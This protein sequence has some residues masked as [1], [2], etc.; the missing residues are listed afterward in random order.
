LLEYPK[1][2]LTTTYF[3]RKNV[4][5]ENKEDKKLILETIYS[6]SGFLLGDG[7]LSVNTNGKNARYTHSTKYEE[8]AYYIIAQLKDLTFTQEIKPYIFKQVN[9]TLSYIYKFASHVHREL[10]PIWQE[11]YKDRIKIV[12]ETLEITQNILLNWFMDDGGL[13]WQAGPGYTLS[14]IRLHSDGFSDKDR[15]ILK[16]KL[17]VLGIYSSVNKRG[18][19][20]IAKKY[21][22][23]FFSYIGEC[24]V[25]CYSYKWC[26]KNKKEYIT[27]KQSLMDNQQPSL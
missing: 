8:Y 6:L 25:K 16:E 20:L 14:N 27:L 19:I 9:G 22:E 4:T 18:N 13:N 12:P 17:Q 24:P 3:E 1:T 7:S 26:Y 15:D 2:S 5:V 21:S 23:L 10:T 11:W